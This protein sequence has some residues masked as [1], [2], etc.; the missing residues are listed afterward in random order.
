M[1]HSKFLFKHF[2]SVHHQYTNPTPWSVTAIHPVE[3]IFVQ[4]TLV[5]PIFLYPVHWRKYD[6]TVRSIT[7]AYAVVRSFC[8]DAYDS[9]A[10][11]NVDFFPPQSRFTAW[12]CTRTITAS[13]NIQESLLSHGGGNP[14]NRTVCFTIT[15]ISTV[16]SI[17]GLTATC[18]IR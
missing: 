3:L 4:L 5:L 8:I 1:F 16:T 10:F 7:V 9:N 6:W 17:T 12:P 11:G 13:Y 2:H 14:G 18:G 15:T